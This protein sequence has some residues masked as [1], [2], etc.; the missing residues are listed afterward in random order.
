MNELI[1]SW[2]EFKTLFHGVNHAV[3]FVT[4]HNEP[5]PLFQYCGINNLPSVFQQPKQLE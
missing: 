3:V 2:H 5:S 4:I 1:T